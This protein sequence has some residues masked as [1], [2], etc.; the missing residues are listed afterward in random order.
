MLCIPLGPAGNLGSAQW[1]ILAFVRARV[2][3]PGENR[4]TFLRTFERKFSN[5]YF[6]LKLLP[7]KDDELVRN[8]KKLGDHRLFFGENMPGKTPKSF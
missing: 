1:F 6:F 2:Y 7:L 3:S 5:I 4:N 8:V